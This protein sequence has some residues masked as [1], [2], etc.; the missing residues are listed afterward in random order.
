VKTIIDDTADDKLSFSSSL[1][2][3]LSTVLGLHLVGD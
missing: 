2:F 3:N 1:I